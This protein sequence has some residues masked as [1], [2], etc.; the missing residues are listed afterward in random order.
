[1]PRQYGVAEARRESLHL[2]LDC[3]RH[4]VN[5]AVW[6]MAVCPG[7]MLPRRRARGIEQTWLR[8]KNKRP[9][10]HESIPGCAF[11]CGDFLQ[12]ASQMDCT[13]SLAGSRA[14]GNR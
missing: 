1:M 3:A 13:G 2:C 7:R 4:V 6:N 8:E 12:C 14:P 9:L 5:R 10:A 11:G